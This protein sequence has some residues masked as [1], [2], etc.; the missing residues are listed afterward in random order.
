[1]KTSVIE[2]R[3]FNELY[4]FNTKHV[5]YV[6]ELE[7]YKTIHGCS[8]AVIGISRYNSDIML[9]VDTAK[10]YSNQSL[11]MSKAK[12][13]IVVPNAKGLL[14][15]LLVDEIV[16]LE[17]VESVETSI[18]LNTEDMIVNHYR[19]SEE[20]NIVNE[21]Y[22][23][24]LLEKHKIPAMASLHIDDE[25]HRYENDT[26][27]RNYLLFT[28]AGKS[29]AIA[30][31]YVK[32]V[33]ENEFEIFELDNVKA[34]QITGAIALRDEIIKLVDFPSE[35]KS[36]IIILEYKNKKIA[37]GVDR[38]YDIEDFSVEK[39]DSLEDDKTSIKAFYNKDAQVIAIV[40]PHYYLAGSIKDTSE[41]KNLKEETLYHNMSQEFLI[42][43]IDNEKFSISMQ[44]VRQVVESDS[45]VKTN[46]SAIGAKKNVA[47]LTTWNR[48]AIEVL[49]LDTYLKNSVNQRDNEII[50]IE[51]NGRFI[52]FLVDSI[53]NIVYLETS[54]I[55]N[56]KEGDIF[57]GAI[58]YENDVIVQL[59]AE[60][61]VDVS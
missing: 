33:L 36:D 29:Y 52:A 28:S 20:D 55:S 18:N 1:M 30:S 42:F 13:V 44:Y 61:L 11:D 23:L 31:K 3:L 32:E 6:Y 41:E 40:N 60:Y 47:F 25:M 57:S 59:N 17:E 56:M 39:I 4:C 58:V 7:E 24:P 38:V 21:I 34:S 53:E 5:K 43:Y 15:G 51:V 49:N 16:K 45:I 27:H 10:L 14:Y 8:E 22:P 12:S 26:K 37:I 9:F 46:A 54:A 35:V 19:E 48:H 2:F 50:F